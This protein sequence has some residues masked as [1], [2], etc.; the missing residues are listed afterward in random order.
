M[1]IELIFAMFLNRMKKCDARVKLLMKLELIIISTID[2]LLHILKADK[3][4]T[5]HQVI[6]YLCYSVKYEFNL[7]LHYLTVHYLELQIVYFTKG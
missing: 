5:Y 7:V 3:D 4:N 1:N 2:I 6:R